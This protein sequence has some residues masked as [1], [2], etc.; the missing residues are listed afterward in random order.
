MP[1]YN[2]Y[3]KTNDFPILPDAW[4]IVLGTSRMPSTTKRILNSSSPYFGLTEQTATG[5]EYSKMFNLWA[6]KYNIPL[7]VIE[8]WNRKAY[9]NATTEEQKNFWEKLVNKVTSTVSNFVQQAGNV[10]QSAGESAAL[11]PLLPFKKAMVNA[12]RRQ[13]EDVS[14]STKLGEVASLFKQKIID[15]SSTTNY[16][17]HADIDFDQI[18][19]LVTT[20]LPFFTVILQKVKEKRATEE[21]K[22]MNADAEEEAQKATSGGAP[23]TTGVNSP[24]EEDF[25][26]KNKFLIIGVVAVVLFLAFRKK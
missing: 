15:R 22:R 17:E 23:T 14:M 7:E 4:T 6:T 5:L 10:L 9:A 19:Q 24:E 11:A 21:E 1:I 20:I 12:L 8:E 16:L 18:M 26:K 25:F 2:A 13:G 3:T